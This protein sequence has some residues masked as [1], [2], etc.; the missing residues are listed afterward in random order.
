MTVCAS[1]LVLALAMSSLD[2]HSQG[3]RGD[4]RRGQGEGGRQAARGQAR[5]LPR[6]AT[7]YR[8]IAYVTNGHP[9]QKLDLYLPRAD[10]RV[11]VILFV[12]GGGF[13]RGDKQ[14]QDPAPFLS[15][16]YAFAT[17]N[18]R[19]SGDAIFP[20]QIEDCKAAVRWLRANA[21]T[22]KLDPDRIGAWGT[23]AG[24]HLVTMLGTTGDTRMFD[25]GENL[26]SS[27]HVQAVADWFGPTDFLQMDAHRLPNGMSHDGTGSPE[28]R[29]IGGPIQ[30]NKEKVA[31]ANPITYIT[32]VDPPFLIAHGDQDRLVPI[33]QSQLLE[34]A[35]KAAGVPVTF[36]TVKG[37]G[38]GLRNAA[39]DEKRKEFFARHLK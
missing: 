26:D 36:I 19:L 23:S 24:G 32:P 16:G 3:R 10:S 33:H 13:S 9:L 38:H 25:V 4:G 17:I 5:S 31:R 7:A 29:L 1:L 18:Y 27:S 30:R 39:A 15:D 6:G 11:P 12:H 14:D 20:A 8:D 28:S 34:A 22:Y 35:L 2:V 21:A 37:A